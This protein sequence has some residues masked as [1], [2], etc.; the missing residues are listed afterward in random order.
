MSNCF[1]SHK[2]WQTYLCSKF[3][4]LKNLNNISYLKYT[5]PQEQNIPRVSFD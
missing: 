4:A 3:K 1:V 2:A 5:E